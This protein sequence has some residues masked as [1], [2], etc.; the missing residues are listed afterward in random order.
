MAN[1]KTIVGFSLALCSA[2]FAAR[3]ASADDDS[4][5][6]DKVAPV[7]EARCVHCHGDDSPKGKLSLTKASGVLKGGESGP[8]IVPGKPDE[9]V[10]L[11]MISGEKPEMP[12]GAPPLPPGDVAQIRRWI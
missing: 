7:L 5:F 6:R 9:S 10:L 1:P 12:K 11:D 3:F 8:A 2:L 4:L